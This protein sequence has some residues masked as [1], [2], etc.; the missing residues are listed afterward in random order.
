MD[1][2]YKH[3]VVWEKQDTKEYMVL[4]IYIS[5]IGTSRNVEV[6]I[7]DSFRVKGMDGAGWAMDI[8]LC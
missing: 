2:L 7:S 3:H 8:S 1:E 4:C 6:R 5:N